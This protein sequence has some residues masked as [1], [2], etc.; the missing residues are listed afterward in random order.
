[1]IEIAADVAED[2]EMAKDAHAPVVLV[3]NLMKT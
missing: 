3:D 1:M 2:A